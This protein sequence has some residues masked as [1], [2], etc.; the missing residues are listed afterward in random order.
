MNFGLLL[1]IIGSRCAAKI[2][3]VF[4]SDGSALSSPQQDISPP[5]INT[6]PSPLIVEAVGPDGAKVDYTVTATDDFDG[7]I[8]PTCN[9]P[10][11]SIFPLGDTTVSCTARDNA[12]NSATAEF[13]V[14]VQDT[15]PPQTEITSAKDG[16][17]HKLTPNDASTVSNKLTISF[18]GTDAVGIDRFECSLDGKAFSRC[19]SS[20]VHN[21]LTFGN[22]IFKVRAVD[23]SGN[24]DQ[25]PAE[26][27]WRVLTPAEGTKKLID[28]IN[29]MDMRANLKSTLNR[30]LNN[31][32]LVLKDNTPDND[33]KACRILDAVSIR[34]H[35]LERYR[36]ITFVDG[37]EIIRQISALKKAIDCDG[38][39]F[40][41]RDVDADKV[42]IY[43]DFLDKARN[44]IRHYY[45]RSN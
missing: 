12:G 36:L 22:H 3:G 38:G 8:N 21:G 13:I 11:G 1:I 37:N 29:N 43:R 31:A 32:L 4:S 10:S 17:N 2:C 40:S 44:Y 30:A 41:I 42:D 25:T 45:S 34:I 14:K 26:F 19:I 28:T 35:I 18:T 15:T 39:L 24:I 6:P 7:P 27:T 33:Y 5:I 20:V 23:I 16:N 9:P